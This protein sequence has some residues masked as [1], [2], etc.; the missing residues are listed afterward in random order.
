MSGDDANLRQLAEQVLN[1]LAV[2]ESGDAQHFP[3]ANAFLLQ[4]QS[5]E[6]AWHIA[7]ALLE[8][9]RIE[10]LLAK[11]IPSANKASLALFA[12]STLR[13]NSCQGQA[14]L[15]AA[16]EAC[17]TRLFALGQ[18]PASNTVSAAANHLGVVAARSAIK[19]AALA[20][21]NKN[22]NSNV[23]T[24]L[25]SFL[26]QVLQAQLGAQALHVLDAVARLLVDDS[27]EEEDLHDGMGYGTRQAL[28]TD[29]GLRVLE[30][31]I[32]FLSS[33]I[34]THPELS[35]DVIASFSRCFGSQ[36]NL[37]S[38]QQVGLVDAL[39]QALCVT[40]DSDAS[41]ACSV[42]QCLYTV[43]YQSDLLPRDRSGDI[44]AVL[45]HVAARL[46]PALA[47]TCSRERA[48]DGNTRLVFD[49]VSDVGA[50]VVSHAVVSQRLHLSLKQH[51]LQSPELA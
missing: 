27:D 28:A 29:F 26:L 7:L 14:A 13:Q 6:H 43:L 34:S 50:A 23:Q 44:A 30:P 19:L 31:L 10:R 47:Q 16:V 1:A 25:C 17:V 20:D 22:E 12:A 39:F 5:S 9:E 15:Q 40:I 49:N 4:L 42:A 33:L 38:L 3:Q 37:L 18:L 41:A 48:D 51:A 2:V 46:L 11:E 32:H 35:A 45:E 21:R 8:F 36:F 24:A